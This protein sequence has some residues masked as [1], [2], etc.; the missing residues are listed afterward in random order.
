VNYGPD[1]SAP[2]ALAAYA[3]L[4]ARWTRD[5]GVALILEPGRAI[6]A[7]IGVLV[8][9]VIYTKRGEARDFLI[10]DAGMNDLIRPALYDAHHEILCVNEAAPGAP[11]TR[12]DVVG[13]V[14]ETADLFARDMELPTRECGDLMAIMTVGAY[15]AV[16]ASA[17]NA[18]PPAPEVLVKGERWSIV[19]PKMSDDELIER[20]RLPPWL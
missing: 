9:R 3:A 11:T 5:L 18:R 8:T 16:M 4:V 14:C 6:A 19:R 1:E 7:D 20:D 13:P 10:V 15:G 12:Y 17:Y 2:P